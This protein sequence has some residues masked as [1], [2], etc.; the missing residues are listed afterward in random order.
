MRSR[1]H[2]I[3]VI[4][5]LSEVSLLMI[6]V[7]QYQADQPE[8]QAAL[9][10]LITSVVERWGSQ[11]EHII[12]GGD[13]NA[14]LRPRV[15]YSERTLTARADVRLLAWSATA[16]LTC[17]APS[18]PTWASANDSR[19]AV[20]DCFFW[21]SRSGQASVSHAEAFVSGDPTLDHCGVKVL[22]RDTRI[23]E[24]PPL[25]ALWRPERLRLDS[26]KNKR[27]EW[28]AAVERTLGSSPRAVHEDRFDALDRVKSVALT[29]ARAI[30]GVTGGKLRS[31]IP[32]HSSAVKHLRAYGCG[33]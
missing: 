21:K 17:E 22:L 18:E 33:G 6:N 2:F 9:L 30:L 13:W 23:V 14:S 16:S 28:R 10:S 29:H 7:Y 11:A 8:Q 24:M 20:L 5:P 1:V 26:W 3:R 27:D 4:D 12:A 15:G 32:F 25:E 19:R 31:L